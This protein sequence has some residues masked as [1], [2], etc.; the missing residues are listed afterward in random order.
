MDDKDHKILTAVQED[1]RRSTR[2]IAQR[3]KLPITTVHNRLRRL[4]GAG[5]IRGYHAEVDYGKIGKG[6]LAYIFLTVDYTKFKNLTQ[7]EIKNKILR[8]INP[9]EV[10]IITGNF[11]IMLKMHFRSTRDISNTIEVLRKIEG[12]DKTQTMIVI[13]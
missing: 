7:S 5:V 1:A 3:V 12:V 9:E 4:E 6:V 13:E 8:T 10:Y 2:E 11:D